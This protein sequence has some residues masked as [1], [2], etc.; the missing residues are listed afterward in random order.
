M[1]HEIWTTGNGAGALRIAGERTFDTIVLDRMLPD[2]SGIDVLNALKAGPNSPPVLMLSALGAL[3]DRVEGLHAGADDYLAKPFALSELDARLGAIARRTPARE[4]A[5]GC[6]SL[7]LDP[8]GH[9]ARFRD[10]TVKLNRKQ[11]SLLALLIRHADEVVTRAML[12]D[13]VW[14]YSFEPTTNIVE[15]NMSR[16]RA[17]LLEL[18]CDPIETVRGLGY[19]LRAEVC[20]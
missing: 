9:H 10:R 5:S 11:F 4:A 3:E 17:S 8:A 13:A 12:F 1:G 7:Q 18:G 15:S 6:G 20:W 2:C 16:L 19:R 14:G